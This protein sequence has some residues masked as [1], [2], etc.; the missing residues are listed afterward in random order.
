MWWQKEEKIQTTIDEEGHYSRFQSKLSN[1]MLL[2]FQSAFQIPEQN[3]SKL[4]LLRIGRSINM[5]VCEIRA[6]CY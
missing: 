3:K 1:V 4:R 6:C 2:N 5:A